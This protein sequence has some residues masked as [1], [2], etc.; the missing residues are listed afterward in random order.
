MYLCPE[1]VLTVISMLPYAL[2][3]SML[4]PGHL[5][6]SEHSSDAFFAHASSCIAG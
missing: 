3:I 5:I 6:A 2:N 4:F 1:N